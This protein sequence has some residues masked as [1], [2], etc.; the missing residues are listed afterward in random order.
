MKLKLE[1]DNGAPDIIKHRL[2]VWCTKADGENA[3]YCL[4]GANDSL[5][6]YNSVNGDIA[7]LKKSFD[8]KWCQDY[9]FE[10]YNVDIWSKTV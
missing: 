9:Y 8:W 10:K 2:D 5:E 6:F 7:E 1:V 3:E 4:Q